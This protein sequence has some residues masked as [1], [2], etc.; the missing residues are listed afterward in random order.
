MTAPTTAAVLPSAS[1]ASRL[2]RGREGLTLGARRVLFLLRARVFGGRSAQAAPAAAGEVGGRHVRR[3]SL[4]SCRWWLARRVLR[5]RDA[6]VP[7]RRRRRRARTRSRRNRGP[8]RI[9]DW[10]TRRWS[11]GRRANAAAR[12]PR[13]SPATAAC[14]TRGASSSLRSCRSQPTLCTAASSTTS[15]RRCM[16]RLVRTIFHNHD[17]PCWSSTPRNSQRFSKAVA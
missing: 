8:G 7:A 10:I 4:I 15:E 17:A 6:R 2:R 1:D 13:C 12:W 3:S 11:A 14:S 16:A 5:P 9:A